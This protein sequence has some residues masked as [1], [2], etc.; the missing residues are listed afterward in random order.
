MT[1]S[2]TDTFNFM[3]RRVSTQFKK[4]ESETQQ[5]P[6]QKE[7]TKKTTNPS[8]SN[9]MSQS[10]SHTCVHVHKKNKPKINP[11]IFCWVWVWVFSRLDQPKTM[12]MSWCVVNEDWAA[13]VDSKQ[14]SILLV[15][16]SALGVDTIKFSELHV[17]LKLEKTGKETNS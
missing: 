14:I 4:I 3:C 10:T 15:S 1:K 6:H 11:R 2:Q 12:R 7:Q 13:S 5:H 9:N 8:S 16:L 17:K